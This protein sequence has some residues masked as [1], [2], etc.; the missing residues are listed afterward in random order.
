MIELRQLEYFLAVCEELH[1]TRAAEKLNI[2]QPSLSQQIK[3]L[4]FAAGMPL[5][6]RLG[7]KIALTAAGKIL[8]THSHR[9]F[10]E[11]EQ[12]H[13]AISDLNGLEKGRLTVGSLKTVSHY[14]LPPAIIR[15]RQSYPNIELSVLGMRTDNILQGLYENELDL[16]ITF[17]P[18]EGNELKSV[19][20]FTEE[21]VLAV[22]NDHSF[23]M[24]DEVEMQALADVPLILFPRGYFLR[25]KID[26]YLADLGI[27]AD[28]TLELT[29]LESLVQMVI[30]GLGATILPEPYVDSIKNDQIKK[31]KLIDP[32]P[33]RHIGF[34][35]RDD[36]FMCTTTKAFMDQIVKTSEFA[37]N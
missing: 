13:A 35:Y 19:R 15:F 6:D 33:E 2:S 28:S 25:M 8:K 12:A 9:M 3:N 20:L 5:F 4:E 7:R 32:T 24:Q 16:G 31:I 1:F 27:K 37:L 11:L 23:A 17:L 26:Q 34:V 29:T 14:L 22:P 21:L 10:F 36:K 30:A 18:V